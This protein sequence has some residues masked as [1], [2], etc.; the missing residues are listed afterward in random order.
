MVVFILLYGG[1]GCGKSALAEDICARFGG[2][3]LYVATMRPFGHGARERVARHRA[4]RAD[5]PFDTAEHYAPP[6]ALALPAGTRYRTLLLEDVGNA[7]AN[8]LFEAALS[9]AQTLAAFARACAGWPAWAEQ[10]LFVANDI[11]SDDQAYPED[12]RRYLGCMAALHA[13]LA[14]RADI[15]IEMVC[16]LPVLHKGQALEQNC[17]NSR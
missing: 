3:G 5:K 8:C 4:M 14:R 7:V 16:G 1:A 6:D 11:F 13:D 10:L 12:T 9:P 17:L 2:R 15:V